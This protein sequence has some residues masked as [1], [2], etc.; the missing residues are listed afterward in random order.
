MVITVMSCDSFIC[1]CLC[2]KYIDKFSR[3]KKRGTT[4]LEKTDVG[5]LLEIE[6]KYI[7]KRSNNNNEQQI[8]ND[9]TPY[10]TQCW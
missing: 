4:S 3:P 1:L 7:K 6:I 2:L 9:I 8:T 10:L 5:T